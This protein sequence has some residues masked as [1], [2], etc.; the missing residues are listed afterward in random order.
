LFV[1][2][3]DGVRIEEPVRVVHWLGEGGVAIFPRTLIIARARSHLAYVEEFVSPDLETPSL[4]CG[5][6]EI[7]ASDGAD[8]QYVALQRWGR[9]VRDV[10]IRNTIAGRDA[11]LDTLVVNL[12]ATVA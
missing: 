11:N 1:H 6:A 8:V 5:V 3:P 7:Y 12:G 10:S 4:C 2:V 9:N